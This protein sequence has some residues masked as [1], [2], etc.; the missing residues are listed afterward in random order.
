[1]K[2]LKYTCMAMLLAS[3]FA[4]TSVA[5]YAQEEA[6]E[7]CAEEA[8]VSAL[9]LAAAAAFFGLPSAFVLARRRR[10]TKK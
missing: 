2:F 8:S 3:A 5:T 6:E 4:F 10:T 7:A 1:M 9:P